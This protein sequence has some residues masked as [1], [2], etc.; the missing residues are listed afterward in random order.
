MDVAFA[1]V[2]KLNDKLIRGNM[3]REWSRSWMINY[4]AEKVSAKKQFAEE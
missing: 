4:F 3:F 1:L 2:K